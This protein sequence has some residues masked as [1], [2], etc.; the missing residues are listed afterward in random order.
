METPTVKIQGEG[1]YYIVINESDFDDTKH[2]LWTEKPPK[3][4]ARPPKEKD[5]E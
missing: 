1:G 3:T 2:Q 4:P 5:P